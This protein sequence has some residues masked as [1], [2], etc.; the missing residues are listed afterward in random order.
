MSK[1]DF[2][3]PLLLEEFYKHTEPL[4]RDGRLTVW[5][6]SKFG[7]YMKP[8]RR[9]LRS[10][11]RLLPIDFPIVR[12]ERHGDIRFVF[13]EQVEGNSAGFAIL[14]PGHWELRINRRREAALVP[15]IMAHELG[16]ALGLE[17]PFYSGDGDHHGKPDQPFWGD[18]WTTDTTTMAYRPGRKPRRCQFKAMDKQALVMIWGRRRPNHRRTA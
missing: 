8:I 10:T 18:Q 5:F 2:S 1:I 9:L 11:E 14:H 12:A 7:P 3:H 6:G 4:A 15:W 13:S 16:H 17:H